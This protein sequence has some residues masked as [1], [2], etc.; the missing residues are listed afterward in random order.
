MLAMDFVVIEYANIFSVKCVCYILDEWDLRKLGLRFGL[1]WRRFLWLR[2]RISR[3]GS[4]HRE[5]DDT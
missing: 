4:K 3:R 5:L 1:Y 2:K